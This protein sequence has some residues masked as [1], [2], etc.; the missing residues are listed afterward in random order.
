MTTLT[1]RG[2]LAQSI[3]VGCIAAGLRIPSFDVI[4]SGS[5]TPATA[6]ATWTP[7]LTPAEQA[8]LDTVRSL[9]VGSVLITPAE[10]QVIDSDIQL[11]VTFQ[12]LASPT[13]AQTVAAVKSQS[14]ILRAILRS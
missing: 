10:R 7:D 4:G 5:L 2:D 14:R 9:A 8:T 13:L 11:L 6:T 12:G 1:V 3:I